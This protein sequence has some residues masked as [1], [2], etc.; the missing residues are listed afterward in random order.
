M[1]CHGDTWLS[2]HL[3]FFQLD[4]SHWGAAQQD[5]FWAELDT[6]LSTRGLYLG[7]V[8]SWAAVYAAAH[9][10]KSPARIWKVLN[11]KLDAARRL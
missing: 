9:A 2:R 3:L 1:K 7:G 4:L 6:W 11:G 10:G 8:P 5:E